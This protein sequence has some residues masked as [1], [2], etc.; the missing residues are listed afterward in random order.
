MS[1]SRDLA[2]PEPALALAL[3]L[4]ALF[5]A[6]FRPSAFGFWESPLA[7]LAR[8]RRWSILIAALVPLAL[9]CLLLPLFGV[10]E[11]RIH[12][13]F[14]FLLG[15]STLLEGRLANAQHPFWVHFESMHILS[16]P[17]YAS[18]FPLAQPAVL[19]LGTMLGHPW[20]G[21]WLSVGLMCGTV[22]WMLQG[23]VPPRWALLGGLLLGIRLGVSSYWMNSYY[24]GALA[25]TGGAFVLGA[26]ARLRLRP[27]WR[28]A[29]L[30]GIGLAILANSRTVEGA[31]YGLLVGAVLA[32]WIFGEGRP[33]WQV[34]IPL[35]LVLALTGVGM[36]F[37]FA[38]VTGSPLTPPYVLY[39][40]T[41][42]MAP[43]FIWQSPRPE[44]LYNNRELRNFYTGPEMADFNRARRA[45]VVELF[46]KLDFYWRFYLGPLLSIPLL[47][48]PWLWQTR[49]NRWMLLMAAGFAPALALQVWHNAHYAAPALGLL[50]LIVVLCMRRLNIWRWRGRPFGRALIQ[51]L[52]LA[53]AAM[54]VVQILVGPGSSDS[55]IVAGW[56]WPRAEGLAR[57]R[58]LR[59]LKDSGEQHLVFVRYG[60]RH[61]TGA[62]WV[63]NEADI[64]GSRVVWARELDRSSNSKLMAYFKNRR[65]WLV[66]P[67][68]PSPKVVPYSSA[69][70]RPMPF[71]SLGAPGIEVLRSVDEVKGKVRA[72][73]KAERL[74]CDQ[75]NYYFTEVTG[76]AGPDAT[77]DCYGDDRGNPVDFERYFAWLRQQR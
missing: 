53:C 59:T 27:R 67:D 22:C 49:E 23:F 51:I 54:L 31:V 30:M 17:S 63:Y 64:D 25:A 41:V 7:R 14:S 75:W 36:G 37:Y 50:I 26:L 11:P 56:R 18:A 74:S 15:S 3:I 70:S 45:L 10:P 32:G 65:V 38:R 5:A 73:V 40:S 60:L 28:Y 24:G 62:E 69:I 43:H 77:P 42:T 29:V 2:N 19:A 34:L 35:G 57:A 8:H 46:G 72:A 47:A 68:L 21:V 6:W 76:V 16:R 44:P 52:P 4:L 71:V 12:D 33:R 55:L 61:E 48:V 1:V 39:R 58:I 66:E 9:R 13:E 20:I